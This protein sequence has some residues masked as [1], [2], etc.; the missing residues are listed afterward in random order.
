MLDPTMCTWQTIFS[1]FM[2]IDIVL[3]FFTAFESS[4]GATEEGEG[5]EDDNDKKEQSGKV[6]ATDQ[7]D[8]EELERL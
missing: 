4:Q 7:D 8:A 1:C 2:V 5:E 6:Q 3:K